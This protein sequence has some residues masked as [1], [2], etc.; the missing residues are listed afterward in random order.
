[1]RKV[2]LRMMITV[3]GVVSDVESWY[4]R[5]EELDNDFI[6][7]LKTIDTGVVG[8]GAYQGMAAYWPTVLENPSASKIEV[9]MAQ[10]LGDMH[11]IVFSQTEEELEWSNSELLLVKDD[12][13][14]VEAVTKLKQQPGKDIETAGGATIAQ[15]F[16]RLGL[17][18]EYRLIVNPVAVG[19]GTRL[20]TDRVDLELVSSKTY[21]SGI[22]SVCYQP[23]QR[24]ELS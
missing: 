16:A 21:K 14:I 20:F 10:A 3:D 22:M 2:I 23:A 17:I 9:A 11:K 7:E 18:D 24:K 4:T 8:Y 15:T 6:A 5:D 13:D 1:M 19:N 12:K